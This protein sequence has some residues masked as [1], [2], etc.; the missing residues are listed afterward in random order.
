[1]STELERVERGPTPGESPG[2]MGTVRFIAKCSGDAEQVLM[3]ARSTLR[4][5]IELSSSGVFDERAWASHL[6]E[7]FVS[8]CIRPPSQEEMDQEMKL[9]LEERV[10][11]Q[12]WQKW[13]VKAFMNSFLPE[14]DMRYWSW[15]DAVVLDKDHIA[16]AVQVSEWPFPWE[17]LRWLLRGSGAIDLEPEP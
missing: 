16:V 7:P 3:T 14:L 5:A 4:S 13:S 2:G 15:W 11:L 17:A 10:E 6:P 8:N 9:P 12:R 1:M